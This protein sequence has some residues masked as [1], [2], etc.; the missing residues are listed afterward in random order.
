MPLP[1][2]VG[3]VFYGGIPRGVDALQRLAVKRISY[4]QANSLTRLVAAAV[5]VSLVAASG[6]LLV[7]AQSQ[8]KPL[9]Q[10]P[11]TLLTLGLGGLALYASS[12]AVAGRRMTALA[13]WGIC[14][15]LLILLPLLQVLPISY[16]TPTLLDLKAFAPPLWPYTLAIPLLF[17]LFLETSLPSVGP[18]NTSNVFLSIGLLAAIMFL[19]F[20]TALIGDIANRSILIFVPHRMFLSVL[21]PI[22]LSGLIVL[23][24]VLARKGLVAAG[25]ALLLVT[26]LG[27]EWMSTWSYDGPHFIDSATI[28]YARYPLLPVLAGTI[29]GILA[30]VAG[31]LAGWEVY[32]KGKRDDRDEH[33]S[34]D[35]S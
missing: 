25:I 15:A 21:T 35:V 18:N 17:F 32:I 5:G 12:F 14:V 26:G 6:V 4:L 23:A 3:V 24:T 34:G 27:I 30:A 2:G 33:I 22:G 16:D 19:F 8:P 7:E 1:N 31:I 9:F 29:P 28:P 10:I 13:C 11:A 20:T